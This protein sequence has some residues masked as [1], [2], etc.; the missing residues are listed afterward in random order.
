MFAT[1]LPKDGGHRGTAILRSNSVIG[2]YQLWSNGPV[3]PRDWECLDGTFYIEAE[4]SPWMVFCHEWQQ[5][6][7]GQI[8]AVRLS[9]DLRTTVG[10]PTLLF[11]ASEA[12]WSAPLKGRA[13]GSYV[14]DGPFIYRTKDGTLLMLWS[15]FGADGG[16]CIGV[17]RSVSGD[18]LGPWTQEEKALYAADGGH[19]MLFHGL[20]DKL[21]LAIHTP[22]KTPNERAIFVELVETD[23]SIKIKA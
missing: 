9:G 18:I 16:Y 3:T 21:Y 12:P 20:D 23:V 6:D 1:F 17:A 15:S 5:V 22:N 10:E 14:T 11:R 13:P 19:G 2:P 4:G 8:C 7:D